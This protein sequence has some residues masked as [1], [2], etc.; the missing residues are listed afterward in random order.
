MKT[1]SDDDLRRFLNQSKLPIPSNRHLRERLTNLFYLSQYVSIKGQANSTLSDF[2]EVVWEK[3]VKGG[4]NET[5][6]RQESREKNLFLL[7]EEYNKTGRSIISPQGLSLD[8]SS[9]DGLEKDEVIVSIPHLGYSF[10]HDIFIDWAEEFIINR[11]W[12]E[13]NHDVDAFLIQLDNNIVTRNAFSRWFDDKVE[14]NDDCVKDFIQKAIENS[15][16]KDWMKSVIS[17]I[18]H[19]KDS[20]ECFV[21]DYEETLLKNGGQLFFTVLNILCVQCVVIDRYVSYEEKQFP[22]MKPKGYGWDATAKFLL[23]AKGIDLERHHDIVYNFLYNFSNKTDSDMSLRHDIGMFILQPY[24][25]IMENEQDDKYFVNR[26]KICTLV[27]NYSLP[28]TKE[29]TEIIRKVVDNKW[30]RYNDP[31]SDLMSYIVKAEESEYA[32][33][34]LYKESPDDILAL[35]SLFWMR[36]SSVE[37]SNE[38]R[39]VI[40][41]EFE[42][43]GLNCYVLNSL[44]YFPASAY[45]TCILPMLNFHPDKTLDFIIKLMNYCIGYYAKSHWLGERCEDIVV[46]FNDGKVHHV[47][48]T[49][50]CWCMVRGSSAPVTPYPLQSI[51]MALEKYLLDSCKDK[52]RIN[53]VKGYLDKILFDSNSVTL[54]AVVASV[55]KAY[56]LYFLDEL[57]IIASNLALLTFDDESTARELSI[58]YLSIG[59]N[60]HSNMLRERTE[61]NKVHNRRN[62]IGRVLVDVQ[63][64]LDAKAPD[65]AEAKQKLNKVYSVI[66]D[67]K[68]Q[69][70]DIKSPLNLKGIISELDYRSMSKKDVKVNGIPATMLTQNL[71]DEQEAASKAIQEQQKQQMPWIT[72][73]NWIMAKWGGNKEVLNNNMYEKEPKKALELAKT[74]MAIDMTDKKLNFIFFPD[75]RY[76]PIGVC[77]LMVQFYYDDL[78]NDDKTL[79][80]NTI[81]QSLKSPE[82]MHGAYLAKLSDVINVIGKLLT[83]RPDLEAEYSDILLI[84]STI[85]EEFQGVNACN[86]VLNFIYTSHLW[87]EHRELMHSLVNKFI[88]NEE[89]IKKCILNR[90]QYHKVDYLAEIW[91]SESLLCIIPCFVGDEQIDKLALENIEKISHIWDRKNEYKNWFVGN[92]SDASTIVARYMLSADEATI[93]KIIRMFVDY[94]Q[95]R[96]MEDIINNLIIYAILDKTYD[97]FWKVWNDLYPYIVSSKGKP[98][99]DEVFKSFLLNPNLYTNKWQE[100]FQFDKR[101]LDFYKRIALDRGRDSRVLFAIVKNTATMGKNYTSQLIPLISEMVSTNSYNSIYDKDDI[102]GSIFYLQK[103]ITGELSNNEQKVK[104]NS[105][106]RQHLLNIL[107]FMENNGSAWAAEMIRNF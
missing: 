36:P 70:R 25:N 71:D 37:K 38:Y 63:Y 65:D 43:W 39:G 60:G 67:L 24:I 48:G 102:S 33:Y 61:S 88:E 47:Y 40:E 81:I 97:N 22:I 103:I 57:L 62:R 13:S 91:K 85:K 66:D 78:S 30:F 42:V 8:Y 46:K 96:D 1:L 107:T 64:N 45:Q 76:I 101:A 50:A 19:Y 53:E 27:G 51:H 95:Y 31:Y 58:S 23:S 74:Y 68:V 69:L 106:Y 79:C 9:I 28:L 80:V 94:L 35:M 4:D 34:P 18:L 90:F 87:E 5:R 6:A 89:Q 12:Y 56:P 54:Y 15:I 7:V 55:A 77:S 29:L 10:A 44:S 21:R 82:F 84:Y 98:V 72:V 100:W 2:K 104:D 86:T 49:A 14:S 41:E 20:S 83:L 59:Y 26:R 75:D 99:Y 17:S 32:N 73:I 11:K 3:K 105:V 16:K 52:D 92:K 93:T